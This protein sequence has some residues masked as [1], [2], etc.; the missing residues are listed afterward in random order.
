MSKQKK[1]GKGSSRNTWFR[2]IV[3]SLQRGKSLSIIGL[4]IA[5]FAASMGY[6]QYLCANN[7]KAYEIKMDDHHREI[8]DYRQQI[9]QL[10]TLNGKALDYFLFV[11]RGSE[12]ER[13][14]TVEYDMFLKKQLNQ[15]DEE[16]GKSR[17]Q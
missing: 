9:Q 11:L 10:K 15:T 4:L 16:N 14:H 17:H 12:V 1:I 7:Y 2:S 13:K 5:A 8:D 6:Q 3:A